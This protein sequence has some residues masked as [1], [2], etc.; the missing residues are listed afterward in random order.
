ATGK[1]NCSK[2]VKSARN[3]CQTPAKHQ[4]LIKFPEWAV[5]PDSCYNSVVVLAI[6]S[7]EGI[8]AVSQRYRTP[9]EELFRLLVRERPAALCRRRGGQTRAGRTGVHRPTLRP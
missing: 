3:F 9:D 6:L 4:E 2:G 8:H 7:R 1:G 5:W